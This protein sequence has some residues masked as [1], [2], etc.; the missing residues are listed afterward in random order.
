MRKRNIAHK[1]LSELH[2]VGTMRERKA[3]MT[4][5]SDGF[6]AMPGGIGTT[7]VV[8]QIEIDL[9]DDN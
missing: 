4:E 9:P 6:I 5:L 7:S 1:S 2:V 3:L 8:W